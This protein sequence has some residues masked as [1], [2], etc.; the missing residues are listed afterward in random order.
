MVWFGLRSFL[1]LGSLT[2][3][4]PSLKGDEETGEPLALLGGG[5]ESSTQGIFLRKPL[6]HWKQLNKQGNAAITVGAGEVWGHHWAT[7][8]RRCSAVILVELVQC[9]QRTWGPQKHLLKP[10]RKER[11]VGG[12]GGHGGFQGVCLCGGPDGGSDGR[13]EGG[14]GHNSGGAGA[15]Q[16][17]AG[18]RGGH[19]LAQKVAQSRSMLSPPRQLVEH[20]PRGRQGQLPRG[21]SW[22]STC[23]PWAW[24]PDT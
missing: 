24:F 13:L 5:Q 8:R 21:H 10:E 22:L 9:G 3:L 4:R 20:L 18:R 12:G 17:R 19:F 7:G 14:R 23:G 11:D 2:R 15:K 6:S 1:D 16:G